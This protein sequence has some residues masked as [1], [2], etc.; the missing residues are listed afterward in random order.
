MV[1]WTLLNS[2]EGSK[3]WVYKPDND[4]TIRK[5]KG[6]FEIYYGAYLATSRRRL[7]KAFE[8]VAD[9]VLTEQ[10]LNMIMGVALV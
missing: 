9:W 6:R 7:S 3:I 8:Y 5:V 1:N 2:K 4:F 10:Y